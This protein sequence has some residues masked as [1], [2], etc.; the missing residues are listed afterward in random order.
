MKMHSMSTTPN[1]AG[2]SLGHVFEQDGFLICSRFYSSS[3]SFVEQLGSSI[4]VCAMAA[5][6]EDQ[7]RLHLPTAVSKI[8][9]TQEMFKDCSWNWVHA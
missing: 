7:L 8:F 3:N 4:L 2:M 1:L 5:F 9:G 6:L